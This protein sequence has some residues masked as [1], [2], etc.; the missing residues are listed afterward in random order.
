L[1]EGKGGLCEGLG[2]GIGFTDEAVSFVRQV[3]DFRAVVRVIG[4]DGG[5]A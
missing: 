5:G 2:A 4:G 1:Q 3:T